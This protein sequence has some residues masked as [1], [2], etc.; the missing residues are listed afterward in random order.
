[1]NMRKINKNVGAHNFNRQLE[2]CEKHDIEHELKIYSTSVQLETNSHIYRCSLTGRDEDIVNVGT[3]SSTFF[4]KELEPFDIRGKYGYR[5]IK[6]AMKGKKIIQWDYKVAAGFQYCDEDFKLQNLKCWSYDIN[7]AFSYAMLS[8]MP[9]TRVEPRYN[10]KI[11]GGEIGF[12]KLGGATTVVGEFA[13]IIFPLI[14]SPFKEYVYTRYEKKKNL[15]K[16]PERDKVKNELNFVTGLLARRNVFMRNAIIY[17]SNK[18]IKKFIDEDTIYCNVDCIVS[19]RPRYD[20]PIGKE[21]GQF[22]IEHECEDFKYKMNGIYQWGT[23]EG[24]DVHY[25]GIPKNLL[26]DIE[27]ISSWQK[28]LKYIFDEKERRIKENVK[29]K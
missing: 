8:P 19:L 9:D 6:D 13:E 24:K 26:S 10:D 2:N 28:N 22:K 3:I 16:G 23:E 11:R 14:D 12:Y 18:Y 29:K 21:I 7:S 1:M 15:P 17:Y 4:N 25:I 27:D 20:I 5:E